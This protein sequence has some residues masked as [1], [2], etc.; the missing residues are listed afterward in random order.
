MK[1]YSVKVFYETFLYREVEAEN[2]ED[3]LDKAYTEIDSTDDEKYREEIV[4]NIS[5]CNDAEITE[6]D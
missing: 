4:R 2:R 6:I 1:K 5:N 3:A